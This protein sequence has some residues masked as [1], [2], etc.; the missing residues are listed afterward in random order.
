MDN[1]KSPQDTKREAPSNAPIQKPPV[2]IETQEVR[3]AAVEKDEAIKKAFAEWNHAIAESDA[4]KVRIMKQ[5]Q[6]K[7]LEEKQFAAQIEAEKV[8]TDESQLKAGHAVAEYDRLNEQARRAEQIR[9]AELKYATQLAEESAAKAVLD[10]ATAATQEA[11]SGLN[12]AEENVRTAEGHVE[13]AKEALL[14]LER[15]L[16]VQK[17][18][19]Q[20]E[21]SKIEACEAGLLAAQDELGLLQAELNA[22]K[23]REELN[24]IPADDVARRAS[25]QAAFDVALEHYDQILEARLPEDEQNIRGEAHEQRVNAMIDTLYDQ[26]SEDV[27]A[28]I[29]QQQQRVQ[30]MSDGK[31]D[32]VQQVSRLT[33]SI[34]L[35]AGRLEE[36]RGHLEATSA[37][38]VIAHDARVNAKNTLMSAQGMQRQA[39][40]QYGLAQRHTAEA[41]RERDSFKEGART[42]RL[43]K[44]EDTV[45]SN[46]A[47][48]APSNHPRTSS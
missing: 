45:N 12:R 36:A 35:T 16:A 3:V 2:P 1:L 15:D 41:A 18:T 22:V 46:V 14:A 4:T 7:A 32:A 21:Q 8:H 27:L 34:A 37:A 24:R 38:L 28:R 29:H 40:D 13:A 42:C 48:T 31:T 20:N 5:E 43:S 17:D 6:Q 47:E 11:E 25:A 30:S 26:T 23:A 19:L 39:Q 44:P 9:L 10:R 33:E